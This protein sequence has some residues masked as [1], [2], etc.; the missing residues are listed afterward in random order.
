MEK[1]IEAWFDNESKLV[2]LAQSECAYYYHHFIITATI[3]ILIAK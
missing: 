1:S 3:I 2:S